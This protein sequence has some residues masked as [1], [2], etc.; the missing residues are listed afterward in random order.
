MTFCAWLSE[1]FH[2]ASAFIEFLLGTSQCTR[3]W[4]WRDER[5]RQ[6]LI[7]WVGGGGEI[8]EWSDSLVG[9]EEAPRRDTLPGLAGVWERGSP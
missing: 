1:S 6:S 3:C 4:G 9:A 5:H 2:S 8:G 7:S